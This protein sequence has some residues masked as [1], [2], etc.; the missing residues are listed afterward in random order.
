MGFMDELRGWN[1]DLVED[2]VARLG[3]TCESKLRQELL[4][5]VTSYL[6]V[7]RRSRGI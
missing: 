1:K 3:T 4:Q 2:L 5:F 7:E 6:A